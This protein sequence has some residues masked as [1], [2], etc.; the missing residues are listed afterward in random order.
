[1]NLGEGSSGCMLMDKDGY[2][3]GIHFGGDPNAQVGISVALYCEGFNYG[4]K[5]GKYNLEGYDLIEGGFPNQKTSYK[6][7]LKK[8]YDGQNIKTKLFPNGLN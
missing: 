5:F 6:Q 3:W 1:A 2:T 7:N 4:G 8:L